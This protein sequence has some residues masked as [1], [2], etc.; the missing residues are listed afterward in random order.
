MER[1]RK[2]FGRSGSVRRKGDGRRRKEKK[3][4]KK[5]SKIRWKLGRKGKAGRVKTAMAIGNGSKGES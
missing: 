2:R 5:S 3:R 4:K 1:R